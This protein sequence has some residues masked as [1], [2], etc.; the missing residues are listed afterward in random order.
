[1]KKTALVLALAVLAA[2]CLSEEKAAFEPPGIPSEE[3]ISEDKAVD[4]G[5]I[6]DS[7]AVPYICALSDKGVETTIWM[8]GIRYYAERRHD[9]LTYRTLYDGS[10]VFLWGE[11]RNETIP[12]ADFGKTSLNPEAVFISEQDM[13]RFAI[14]AKCVPR[15]FR[16]NRL[17]PPLDL[18]PEE[19][20]TAVQ[21]P[22]DGGGYATDEVLT[23][24]NACELCGIIEDQEQ[25]A[26]CVEECQSAKDGGNNTG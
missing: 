9:G 22:E 21:N 20:K 24:E 18:F 17:T 3:S 12:L 26:Q 13:M 19:N 23:D 4:A 25:R 10:K 1:M 15:K 2:G 7:P 11:G 6:G 5:V 16:L 14:S 8:M